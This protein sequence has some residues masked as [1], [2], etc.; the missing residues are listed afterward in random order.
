MRMSKALLFD[1]MS[2][3]GVTAMLVAAACAAG[4]SPAPRHHQVIIGMS[5]APAEWK[6]RL[7]ETGPVGARRLYGKL[8]DAQQALQLAR[9]EIAA[10]RLPILSFKVPGDDWIGAAAGRY[11]GQL[12]TIVRAL[13]AMPGRSVVAIHHE[14]T[15][16]GTPAAYA[17]MQRHML[18]IIAAPRNVDAA[19]VV[20]GFWWSEQQ[21]RL[22]DAEIAE[23]LPAD[24]LK[25]TEIVAADTYQGGKPDNP[26]EDAGVKIRDLSAWARRVGVMRL[27]IA[28]YNGLTAEALTNAGA[29]ILA[30]DRYDFGICFNSDRNNRA[31]VHWLLVGN[32][33][34]AFRNTLAQAKAR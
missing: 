3:I 1:G 22:T 13:A 31:G 24:V 30:D 29:A 4:Q 10:G 33:L 8:D 34:A 23:W 21:Q 9:S 2:L 11:D 17:A 6:Q 14:P 19:V 28:E 7:A 27:G 18:P 12:S 5:A 25:V 20:N 16:D 26:G 32:R 15:G